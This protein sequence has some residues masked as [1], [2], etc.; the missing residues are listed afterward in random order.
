MRRGGRRGV[1]G[2]TP[3]TNPRSPDEEANGPATQYRERSDAKGHLTRPYAYILLNIPK[4]STPTP[5]YRW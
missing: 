2:G 4:T 5:V 1:P 3:R